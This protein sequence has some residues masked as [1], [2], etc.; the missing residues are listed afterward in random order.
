MP[1]KKKVKNK[2]KSFS[3]QDI[4]MSLQKSKLHNLFLR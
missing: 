2:N 1:A 3:F 4:I